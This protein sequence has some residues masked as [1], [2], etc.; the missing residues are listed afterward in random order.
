MI[1]LLAKRILVSS[2]LLLTTLQISAH[3]VWLEQD[4]SGSVRVY[5]GEPGVPD[6]GNKIDKL[7]GSHVFTTDTNDIAPLNQLNDHWQ[8]NINDD[9]DVRLFTESVWQ[10]WAI[11]ENPWW[12]FW[13]SD[14]EHFQGAI[15]QARAGRNETTA[16]LNFELVPVTTNGNVF[17]A[18]F[19]EKP[20][21][22]QAV[23]LL[24]P[25]KKMIELLTDD[26]G[27]LT[28]SSEEKGRFILSSVHTVDKKAMH[29]GKQVDSLMYITSLSFVVL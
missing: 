15:L 22:N 29:S 10:P 26:N 2:L 7:A 6:T 21:A 9:G 3:E 28:V 11:N 14:D 25:N 8:A 27:Q 4:K 1:N 20:L 24:S 19:E 16:K 12:N 13:A 17:T 23:E 18:I 5:L